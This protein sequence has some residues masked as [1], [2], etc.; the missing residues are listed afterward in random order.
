MFLFF[1]ISSYR[2]YIFLSFYL[3]RR[4]NERKRPKRK[5]REAN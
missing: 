3:E 5:A 4:E 1:I 2:I